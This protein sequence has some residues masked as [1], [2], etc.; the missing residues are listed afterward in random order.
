MANTNILG[1]ARSRVDGPLKVTGR[2][3]YAVEFEIP[4]CAHAWPVVSTISKGTITAMD[5]KAAESAPGVLKV[6]THQNAPQPTEAS[7][8][9]GAARSEG[10]RIEE[11]NPLSDD[12]VHYAGQFIALVVAQT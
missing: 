10:I 12:K 8:G 7:G 1:P 5:T 4:R 9:G 11:R 2:A 3:K 6:L